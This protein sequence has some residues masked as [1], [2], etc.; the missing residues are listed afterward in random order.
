MSRKQCAG[1]N[2]LNVLHTLGVVWLLLGLSYGF[3]VQAAD[4]EDGF[5]PIFNGKNLDG[6]DGDPR[7]W[8]VREGAIVGQTTADNPTEHNTFLIWRQGQVDDFELRLS[9]RITGGN[10]GVQYRSQD[11]GDWIA[12]GYQADIDSGPNY[13]G[14]FYEERGRGILALRGQRTSIA[15]NGE[16]VSEEAFGTSADLQQHVKTNDWNDYIIKAEGNRLTHIINDRVM[17]EVVD[18]QTGELSRLGILAFQVHA[19][20]P[21]KVEFKDIRLKRLPL[22][23][24]KKIV[25]VAGAPSH[26]NGQHEHNAGMLLLQKCLN[27]SSDAVTTVYRNGWPGDPTA[28]DNADTIGIYMDGG[29][30]H[31]MIQG[32]RLTQIG[33]KVSEGVGLVFIHYAVEVPADRGGKEMLDWIGGYYETGFSTNPVWLA[34]LNVTPNHPVTR[35]VEPAEIHDEWYFN[36][37]FRPDMKGITPLFRATPPDEVR[38]RNEYA[39]AAKGREEVIAWCVDRPDGGRGFGF[40]GAHFHKNWGNDSFRKLILNAL[41]WTAKLDVPAAGVASTIT[42][43]DLEANLD[44]K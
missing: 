21:M 5:V 27:Q 38:D 40:T 1:V 2:R 26:G 28:F 29:A 31:P 19:G 22:K 20:D 12:K 16:K 32:D 8:S 7:F 39:K 34:K 15:E 18:K 4:E 14:I 30:G 44:E 43:D 6:W 37:R 24:K 13:S 17:S 35:G 25:L 3:A 10:S 11:L 36:I 33:R 42:E 23:D 41:Y 9:Y